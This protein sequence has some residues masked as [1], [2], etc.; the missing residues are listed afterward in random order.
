MDT[1]TRETL[2]GLGIIPE[3]V[4]PGSM[5]F[6]NW[7]A[8]QSL[9]EKSHDCRQWIRNPN[10]REAI[11]Y[12]VDSEHKPCVG[13][14]LRNL[15]TGLKKDHKAI[16][17]DISPLWHNFIHALPQVYKLGVA[18]LCEGPKDAR[19][20]ASAGIPAIACLGVIPS[21]EHLRVI[22]RYAGT[23][24]WIGDQDQVDDGRAEIRLLRAKRQSRELGIGFYTYR[25]SAKDPAELAG[26]T[27]ELQRIRDRMLELSSFSR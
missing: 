20:L 26:N 1:R 18:V 14:V 22:R 16:T 12:S 4:P 21:H 9:G 5:R 17:P 15:H 6:L 25:I 2:L 7:R 19:V 23:V 3:T 13:V 24:L 8:L 27:E 10:N 11:G